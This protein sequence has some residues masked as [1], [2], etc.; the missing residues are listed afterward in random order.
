MATVLWCVA[1]GS[2]APA[3]RYSGR[4]EGRAFHYTSYGDP[5]SV[6]VEPG[7]WMSIGVGGVQI[8]TATCFTVLAAH[9]HR[10]VARV[11]TDEDGFFSVTLKPGRYLLVPDDLQVPAFPQ[12]AVIPLAPIEIQ[13]KA[14]R[15]TTKNL[16]Y[17]SVS[18]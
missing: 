7:V 16:F 11:H 17:F 15:V 3:S 8:P 2:A 18:S 5:I 12:A 14:R 1:S 9:N 13:V 6:E 10:E 4:I